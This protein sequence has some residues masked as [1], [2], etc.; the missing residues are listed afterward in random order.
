MGRRQ[1]RPLLRP[2]CKL[3]P[4]RG[5]TARGVALF[6]RR[7]P[8]EGPGL[9]AVRFSRPRSKMRSTR[10]WVWLGA[11]HPVQACRRAESRGAPGIRLP[12]RPPLRQPRLAPPLGQ[13]RRPR[14]P[15]RSTRE[16]GRPWKTRA[17]KWRSR[18]RCGR[19]VGRQK[20]CPIRASRP[21][22][23]RSSAPSS[24]GARRTCAEPTNASVPPADFKAG[25]DRFLNAPR[26]PSGFA[27]CVGW[28]GAERISRREGAGFAPGRCRLRV[29]L[30]V[31]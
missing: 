18:R 30:R 11:R 6:E 21:S 10:P 27:R 19:F 4:S 28:A 20:R 16:S 3:D 5:R 24:L 31:C 23:L 14:D 7:H 29:R 2:G 25:A 15:G 13:T 17:M 22:K 12:P 9:A 1:R 8:N 26:P